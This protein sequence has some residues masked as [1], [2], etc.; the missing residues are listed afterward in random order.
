M[1]TPSLLFGR[2][3]LVRPPLVSITMPLR[4]SGINHFSCETFTQQTFLFITA[5]WGTIYATVLHKNLEVPLTI[6][7]VRRHL[8]RNV[9]TP[10]YTDG[11]RKCAKCDDHG[12]P[13][14]QGWLG[15]LSRRP[16]CVNNGPLCSTVTTLFSLVA[17]LCVTVVT[18]CGL[19]IALRSL[20]S[21]S[22]SS[23]RRRTEKT[24]NEHCS[25]LS[26]LWHRCGYQVYCEYQGQ[27]Y[28]DCV[29]VPGMCFLC[30]PLN[31]SKGC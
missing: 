2:P 31:Y 15:R 8:P 14:N 24:H 12:W 9:G 5:L 22:G 16:W 30:I 25:S 23:T 29:D 4:S 26:K 3:P 13:R 28:S 10:T 18:F 7:C 11:A 20:S 19:V 21:S 6:L 1:R 17:L 27:L